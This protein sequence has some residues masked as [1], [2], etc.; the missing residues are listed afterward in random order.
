M[1]VLLAATLALV[2]AGGADAQ[3]RDL[4][5]APT[6]TAASGPLAAPRL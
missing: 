6:L 1:R 2:L 3:V 5:P 4:G